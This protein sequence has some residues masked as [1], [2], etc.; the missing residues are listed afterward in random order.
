MEL[1]WIIHFLCCATRNFSIKWSSTLND[2]EHYDE[3]KTVQLL[4]I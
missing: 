3:Q 4:Y 1:F 2:L